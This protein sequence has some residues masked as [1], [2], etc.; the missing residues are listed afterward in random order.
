MN[1]LEL[2]KTL[3]SEAG[4]EL[5]NFLMD[6]IIKLRDISNLRDYETP[7]AQTIELKAQKK[8]LEKLKSILNKVVSLQ[9]INNTSIEKDQFFA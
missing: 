6:E 3:D 7:T 9:D 1:L 2:K 4:Q 5:K 8:A